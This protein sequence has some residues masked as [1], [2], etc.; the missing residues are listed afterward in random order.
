MGGALGLAIL[1]SGAAAHT[2]AIA[3]T[4]VTGDEALNGGYHLAFALGAAC[5]AVAAI[6]ATLLREKRLKEDAPGVT[7]A[8]EVGTL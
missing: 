5:A 3:S 8:H 1:A 4:G 6:A 2:N 7:R